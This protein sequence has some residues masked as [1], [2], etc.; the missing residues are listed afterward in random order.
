MRFLKILTIEN[1]SKSFLQY[2]T[3]MIG[4]NS[5]TKAVLQNYGNK[6]IPVLQNSPNDRNKKA[7]K[8][9]TFREY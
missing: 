5:P 7:I 2:V 6:Y 8:N 9:C 1:I 4:L 3:L